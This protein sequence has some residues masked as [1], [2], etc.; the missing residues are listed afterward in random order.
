ML[1]IER[2]AS[3]RRRSITAADDKPTL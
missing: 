2:T 3:G 1:T